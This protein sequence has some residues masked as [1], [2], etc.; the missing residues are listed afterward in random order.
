MNISVHR[1]TNVTEEVIHHRLDPVW[2]L[3]RI[4]IHTND[5]VVIKLELF[6][7]D[8]YSMMTSKIE[9]YEHA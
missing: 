4:H 9:E 3:R 8:A 5:G 6:G 7:D 2:H 1:V